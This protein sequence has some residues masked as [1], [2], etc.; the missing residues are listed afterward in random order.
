MRGARDGQGPPPCPAPAPLARSALAPAGRTVGVS[1]WSK[2]WGWRVAGEGH[3]ARAEQVPRS[4]WRELLASLMAPHNSVRVHP[5]GGKPPRHRAPSF[6]VTRWRNYGIHGGGGPGPGLG[7]RS[8]WTTLGRRGQAGALGGFGPWRSAAP[9]P[10]CAGLPLQALQ[11]PQRVQPSPTLPLPHGR[12]PGPWGRGGEACG[13]GGWGR[14][15]VQQ[16]GGRQ[17]GWELA[18]RPGCPSKT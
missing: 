4:R 6:W 3:G 2:G 16:A 17:P 12:H 5:Q 7:S 13:V 14:V 1:S 9:S 11:L 18:P 8:L 10:L 15:W